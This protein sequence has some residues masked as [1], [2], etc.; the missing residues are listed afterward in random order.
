[1]SIRVHRKCAHCADRLSGAYVRYTMSAF[2]GKA[3]GESAAD[4]ACPRRRGDRVKRREVITLVSSAAAAWPP[5][6]VQP[7]PCVAVSIAGAKVKS[8]I[9]MSHFGNSSSKCDAS[10]SYPSLRLGIPH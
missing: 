3:D 4:V 5:A 7:A 2:G 1:S 9:R 10:Q 6:V 8:A